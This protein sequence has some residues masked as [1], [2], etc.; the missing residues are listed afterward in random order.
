MGVSSSILGAST[1]LRMGE[2]VVV[3]CVDGALTTE[4]ALF[5][6]GEIVLRSSD[7]VSVREMGYITTAREALARFARLGITPE[8]ASEAARAV[9]PGVLATY[10]RGQSVRSLVPTLGPAEIFEGSVFRAADGFY[11]GAWLDLGALV[12]ALGGGKGGATARGIGATARGTGAALASP[13]TRRDAPRVL[14]ALHL[15]VVLSEVSGNTPV[16][17]ATAN[18]TRKSR[19]GERTYRRV[20]LDAA[21]HVVSALAA[22]PPNPRPIDLDR[23]AED[24]LREALLGRV[25]ERASGQASPQL[26]AHLE[27]LESALLSGAAPRH[28]MSNAEL[29]RIEQQLAAGSAHD[30]DAQLDELEIRLGP[31]A[32]VR[33]LRARAALVRGDQPPHKVA[34]TLSAIANEEANFHEVQLVAARAWLAAGEE[35]HARYFARL[36]AEDVSASDGA[37]LVALEILDATAKATQSFAPPPAATQS[38]TPP[39]AMTLS[40]APPEAATP[41]VA[42]PTARAGSF[43]PSPVAGGAADVANGPIVG[44]PDRHA[45]VPEGEVDRALRDAPPGASLPPL[46]PAPPRA[47]KATAPGAAAEREPSPVPKAGPSP[48]PARPVRY[49]P[50]IVESLPLPSDASETELPVGETPA[51]PTQA[52][53]AMVRLARTLARDYRLWYGATL[54]CNVIA[55]DVMQRHL[56]Q[57]FAG[58]SLANAKTTSELLRHG[59]LLSE[60][61]AR[62]LGGAWVDVSP[63]ECG[64]WAM[65]VPPATRCWPI[66]RVY[67]FVALGHHERDLV[68]YYLDLEKRARHG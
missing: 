21:L 37:R 39:P 13:A 46:T 68:S 40:S 50:E 3:R 48:V 61:I 15:A 24:T 29:R 34:Q 41:S 22:I 63:T 32:G 19:S 1:S 47:S 60:I 18:L 26:R 8:L 55:I 38:F 23:D 4:Y 66:G 59:A 12:G 20:P 44:P 16:Q 56:S 42:L 5:E 14:Q 43:A 58:A 31:T 62:A 67:R 64:Y 54:R 28:R 52:R 27:L 25:R 6:Q 36:L 17:L 2:R 49:D 7:P 45:W 65:Q 10:A 51:T 33:Y 35:A 9:A 11:E 57:R 53:V 30:V